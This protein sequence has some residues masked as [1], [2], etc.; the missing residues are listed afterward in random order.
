MIFLF[1]LTFLFF[2][3]SSLSPVGLHYSLSG[4]EVYSKLSGC[5]LY[6]TTG[7]SY[8]LYELD[9]PLVINY[10]I[11]CASSTSLYNCMNLCTLIRVVV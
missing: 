7:I 1:G 8:F 6:R 4:G 5:T 2:P 10:S 11:L 9:S 3:Y